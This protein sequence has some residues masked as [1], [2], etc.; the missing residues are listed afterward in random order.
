M[1]ERETDKGRGNLSG[2][3]NEDKKEFVKDN[4]SWNDGKRRESEGANV[5]LKPGVIAFHQENLGTA[6]IHLWQ[7]R[8]NLCDKIPD[9][10][11]LSIGGS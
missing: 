4:V 2:N 7:R 1:C 6:M 10:T 3:V 8:Q 9:I 11:I 5:D